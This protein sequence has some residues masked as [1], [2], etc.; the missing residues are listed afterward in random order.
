VAAR[1]AAKPKTTLDLD[2]LFIK[3]ESFLFKR[4]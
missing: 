4:N 1:T 2:F 3:N